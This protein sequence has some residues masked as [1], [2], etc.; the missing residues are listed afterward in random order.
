M[1]LGG[2]SEEVSLVVLGGGVV[3]LVFGVASTMDGLGW[4]GV[5]NVASFLGSALGDIFLIGV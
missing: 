5:M 1:I 4:E 2:S 3:L